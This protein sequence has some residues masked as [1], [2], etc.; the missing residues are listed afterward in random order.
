MDRY[1]VEIRNNRI[2]ESQGEPVDFD[3]AVSVDD[4]DMTNVPYHS[5]INYMAPEL[6]YREDAD[7]RA[8]LYSLGAT[9]Y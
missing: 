7:E 8:D 4:Q 6:I 5:V 1:A 3:T 2:P 9:I